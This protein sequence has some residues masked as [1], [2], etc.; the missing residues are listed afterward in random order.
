MKKAVLACFLF[1]L[2]VGIVFSQDNGIDPDDNVDDEVEQLVNDEGVA[3]VI[4]VLEDDPE[5][6]NSDYSASEI[7]RM[8]DDEKEK[9]MIEEQQ[10]IVLENLDLKEDIGILSNNYDFEL[11]SKFSIVNGFSGEVTEEGLEKLKN[12]ENVKSVYPNR[13]VSAFLSDTKNIVNA[14]KTWSLI[15]NSTNLTGKGETV[16]IIDTGVDYTHSDMGNCTVTSNING[17]SCGKV[18][19][20]YDFINTDENPMDD[21]GHGTHVAGIVASTNRTNRGI[22]PDSNIVAIKALDS[23]GAG[24]TQN[25]ID[26]I[27]WCVYNSSIFNITVISMSLGAS[28]FSSY[29]DSDDSGTAAAINAAIARNISVISA[30]GNTNGNFPTATAGIATPACIRNS[31]RVTAVD[32]SD[33]MANYAFRHSSF[34]DILAAPGTSII[35]LNDG[36][37]FISNTGTS[38]SAP[39][40]AGA[41]ALLHQYFKLTEN[42]NA[43][44]AEIQN[45]LNDTGKQI[46]DSGTG[47]A[48]SRI[49]IL[50]AIASLDTTPPNITITSPAN[51]SARTNITFL[52]NV[53]ANEVLSNATLETNNTNFTMSGSG[54][55]WSANISGLLNR[56][57]DYKI[58]ANDTFGNGAIFGIFTIN[59][60][61]IPPH[62]SGNLTNFSNS[63][64]GED[65]KFEIAWHDEVSLSEFIF[66]WND[67]GIFD[68][69]TLGMLSGKFNLLTINKTITATRGKVVGY[70]FYA[71]DSVGNVNETEVNT[72]TIA[73]TIP[74]AANV[75]INS[76]DNLNRTNGTLVGNW[77]FTDIDGDGQTAN[78]IKWYKNGI[79]DISLRNLT[80]I[81]AANTTKNDT[82]NFSVSVYDGFDSSDFVNVSILIRNAKPELNINATSIRLSE[83]QRIN[84]S[85][86]ASDID[87]DPLNFTV[88]DSR[89]NLNGTNFIWNTSLGD[90]GSYRINITVNDSTDIDS[91]VINIT[92]NAAADTDGDGTPD[93]S[94][95]DDDDDGVNDDIDAVKGN[96]SSINTTIQNLSIF[97]GDSTNISKAF[98]GSHTINFTRNNLTILSFDF[99]FSEG[100]D[101]VSKAINEG[102]SETLSVNGKDYLVTVDFID[103]VKTRL[104]VNS[105]TTSLLNV[106]DS[107]TLSDGAIAGV[108]DILYQDYAGGVHSAT[109]YIASKNS[110]YLDFSRLTVNQTMVGS[111]AIS[112]KGLN[113]SKYG[114]TK[115]AFL[116]KVNSTVDSVCIKDIET[117]F[118]TISS[119]CSG[120]NEVLITCN[121]QTSSGYTCFDTGTSYKVTGLGHSAVKELCADNDGDGYGTGCSLGSDCNDNSFSS[122]NSCSSGSSDSGSSGGS[123]GG[124]G[125]GGGGGSGLS[126]T[127]NMDWSCGEWSE[128]DGSWETRECSFIK[129]PQHTQSERCPSADAVPET[130]RKCEIAKEPLSLSENEEKADSN[131]QANGSAMLT[132][133]VVAETGK[134]AKLSL[135]MIIILATVSIGLASY[136][137]ARKIKNFK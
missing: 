2:A 114:K 87:N 104:T 38:M 122:T 81:S 16:C 102:N 92:I 29:C 30:T 119:A 47:S 24:T 125:G 37:G 8:D 49:N 59:I 10:E 63:K 17:G 23:S 54:T 44:P 78:E 90:A 71:N 61:M 28:Q 134:D 50:A 45:A 56:T 86:N 79:E 60:D 106:N 116:N 12:D 42:R 93:F 105:Q 25:V 3:S 5:S 99:N 66:S 95:P 55:S 98:N 40:V 35:S 112:I 132:G 129:V 128:C 22:S 1:L 115:T 127:C 70:K 136:F 20:G 69:L 76:S 53:A 133:A 65:V 123:G 67:T 108:L 118:D 48:F 85:L 135:G 72:I 124:G 11:E 15:Y 73:N 117:T 68:N 107:Y 100:V 6:L 89:F 80:L 58:Y 62:F 75:S 31:T 120:S 130:A 34:P 9:A 111:S 131:A 26:G 91:M 51:D 33:A 39:H 77:T 19:G 74:I 46:A 18:I 4:V 96:V 109:I 21:H 82:W 84:I 121:N 137:L 88:N 41:F 27:N 110:S 64:K 14:S 113:L 7:S 83:A 43:T 57:Y 13:P 52:V 36:G 32:K 101:N 94:D 103:S 126:Y 97:I